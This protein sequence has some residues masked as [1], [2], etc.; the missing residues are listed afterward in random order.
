MYIHLFHVR[1]VKN[2]CTMSG[3]IF[4]Y[5]IIAKKI[6]KESR[7]YRLPKESNTRA[8]PGNQ[9]NVSYSLGGKF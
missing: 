4:I 5:S 9:A 3:L 8:T 1:T 6:Q 2:N 7:D